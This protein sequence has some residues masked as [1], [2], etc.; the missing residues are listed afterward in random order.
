MRRNKSN[1]RRAQK[2]I[3]AISN[4]KGILA[5]SAAATAF[6]SSQNA[7]ASNTNFEW[8]IPSAAATVV[9]PAGGIT[10]DVQTPTITYVLAINDNG[11]GVYTPNSF[12]IYAVDGTVQTN[13]PTNSTSMV[14]TGVTIGTDGGILGYG[15]QVAN[16]H[17]LRD[18][19]QSGSLATGHTA[20]G[21]N[22]KL[23]TNTFYQILPTNATGGTTP[24]NVQ[25]G[26]TYPVGLDTLSTIAGQQQQIDVPPPSPAQAASA[27]GTTAI[28][29]YGLGKT[30]GSLGGDFYYSAPAASGY[31]YGS[32]TGAP[33]TGKYTFSGPVTA[34]NPNSSGNLYL[35]SLLVGE[36]TFT[37]SLPSLYEVGASTVDLSNGLYTS[38][39]ETYNNGYSGVSSVAVAYFTETLGTSSPVPEPA[40]LGLLTVGAMGLLA[41]RRR[42]HAPKAD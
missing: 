26:F 17:T 30:G 8:N 19:I 42:R 21:K 9:V 25:A 12:A 39:N 33:H 36:G 38:S 1:R 23:Q 24:T 31:N 20:G 7:Q 29:V 40:S 37:T 3:R 41:R 5:V 35:T 18:D 11:W 15:V 13:S 14:P 2:A 22:G 16:A 28:Q 6:C 32:G 27:G 34:V 10:P 4:N